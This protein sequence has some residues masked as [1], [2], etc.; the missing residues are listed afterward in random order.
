MSFK[1]A[2]RGATFAS[3]GIA[4]AACGNNDAEIKAYAKKQGMSDIQTAAFSACAQDLSRNKPVFRIPGGNMV[5]LEVPF[6][7]CA[8]QSKTILTVFKGKQFK[9]HTAFAEYMATYG[10]KKPPHFSK[11][12]LQPGLKPKE[13]RSQLVASLQSCATAYKSAH[14]KQ[15]T[16]IFKIVPTKQ[17]KVKK[18]THA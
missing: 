17:K 14:E 7:V 2:V 11:K 13:A 3:L 9:G 5:M 12:S 4:L 18:A 8:C 15:S 6:E 1:H 16:E 10:K